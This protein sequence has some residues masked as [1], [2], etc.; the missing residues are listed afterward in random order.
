[1]LRK[2]RANHQPIDASYIIPRT[3]HKVSKTDISINALKVLNRLNSAGFQA[4]LVGGSVRDLL[5][6]KAPKDFDIATNAT[7]NQIKKLFRNA[8]I[9]GRR[10]KLVHIIF[11]RDIIEVA[12]FRKSSE[13]ENE[14]MAEHQYTNERGMLVRDNVYGT[15]D[16]DAWRRDFTVNSLYYNID[17]ASIVDFTGGVNDVH[18]RLLRII[19]D[20]DKRYQE[21]PVRMLRAIRF[22]AKLHFELAPET[23]AP[24]PKLSHLIR[25]V[26][27][28]RLFDEMTKLYQCG[29]AE[30][31][32]RLL[33][34]HGLFPH[35]FE[36]TANLFASEYP[37]K[38]LLGIALENTDTR[39]RDEKPVTPAFLFAVLLW[40]P[41]KAQALA[42]QESEGL[43]PLPALEKAMSQVIFE[44]N[45]VI[46]IPKRFS[47]I[48]REI[49]LLQFRFPKRF[50][51]RAFNLLQH[52]RFRAAYDFLAL[53]AL[54]GDESLELAQWWTTFQESDAKEQ[55]AMVAAL[56]PK[57]LPHKNRKKRKPKTITS[58]E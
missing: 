16:E 28:S 19:G 17:D 34:E 56:S 26:S 57:T 2:S 42:L 29:E 21:D 3:Q 47:Q 1:M 24:L 25:H 54:A 52:P 39:I 58:S 35:L 44:Q 33:V 13:S 14:L 23:A 38:A 49:W 27:G 7:P 18:E 8:R 36:Q 9:I 12:T 22:S 55:A 31:V 30:T 11:H 43:D 41:L 50:G 4:Y 32:Q 37:V 20:P 53:R 15:L 40:F 45:K 46:T 51:G 48:I 5:L 10:F 6:G